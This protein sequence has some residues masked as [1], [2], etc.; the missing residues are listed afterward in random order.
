MENTRK[1]IWIQSSEN[2]LLWTK[3]IEPKCFIWISFQGNFL[4]TEIISPH[5]FWGE[6]YFDEKFLISCDV[7]YKFE[8]IWAR[9]WELQMQNVFDIKAGNHKHSNMEYW[10][11]RKR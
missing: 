3:K 2:K 7:K 1:Y 8:T 10:F 9:H 11:K 6:K 4:R 5:Y